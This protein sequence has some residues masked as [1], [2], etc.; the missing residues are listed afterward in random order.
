MEVVLKIG[1]E[2][3]AGDKVLERG[4]VLP[5]VYFSIKVGREYPRIVVLISRIDIAGLVG[6]GPAGI[7]RTVVEPI[8][9]VKLEEPV[10]LVVRVK[11]LHDVDLIVEAARIFLGI[12]RIKGIDTDKARHL[13]SRV[14]TVREFVIEV[15]EG[16]RIQEGED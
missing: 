1:P 10:D 7:L 4:A 14:G 16:R 5:V 8:F 12:V 13:V 11:A 9:C 6:I 2:K 15:E 3:G